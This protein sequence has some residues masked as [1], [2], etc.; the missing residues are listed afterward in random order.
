MRVLAQIWNRNKPSLKQ[1][2]KEA[3][4]DKLSII[5][6][7][8]S[9]SVLKEKD[10]FLADTS[11]VKRTVPFKFEFILNEHDIQQDSGNP[12]DNIPEH[13]LDVVLE[14][15]NADKVMLSMISSL[16]LQLLARYSIGN[17]CSNFH[18]IIFELLDGGCGAAYESGPECLQ[19]NP[20]PEFRI[21][22]VW[23]TS[24]ECKA[25]NVREKID[26]KWAAAKRKRMQERNRRKRE[27]QL[28]MV[29]GE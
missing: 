25:K 16:Q 8:E 15:N 20:N 3:S 7:T 26:E 2:M 11:L 13:N 28:N 5:V 24:N 19:T 29:K 1:A 17:C 23:D 12:R 21:C 22:C 18:R 4:V 14:E 27:K 6:T 10:T 9:A